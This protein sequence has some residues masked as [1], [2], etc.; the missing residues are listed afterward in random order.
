MT[1]AR[2]T[3]PPTRIPRTESSQKTRWV[4]RLATR[5]VRMPGRL[6]TSG[7]IRWRMSMPVMAT[8]AARKTAAT[9]KSTVGP[10]SSHA[11]RNTAAVTISTSGYCQEIA[12][13]QVRQRPRSA[14]NESTGTLSCHASA[15]PQPG[16][17]EAG[18]HRLR[19]SGRRRIT[20]LRK[21]PTASPRRPT[22]TAAPTGQA[23]GASPVISPFRHERGGDEPRHLGI[24]HPEDAVGGAGRPQVAEV[25][26]HLRQPEPRLRGVELDLDG[27]PVVQERLLRPAQLDQGQA[28]V[29][30]GEGELGLELD[31]S[32]QHAE[33]L[34]R[35]ARAD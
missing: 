1:M 4:A 22:V 5:P 17:A 26:V 10:S 21:L 6:M 35:P 9:T 7:M 18:R 15:V 23:S 12:I 25:D 13:P 14:R 33:G 27:A 32:A 2:N 30:V 19:P 24:E 20:T 31:G 29:R 16:H 28:E 3:P 11:S 34:F 8:S